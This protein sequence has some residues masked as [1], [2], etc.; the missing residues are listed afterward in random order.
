MKS[1]SVDLKEFGILILALHP[2]WVKTRMGGKN[3]PIETEACVRTMIKTLEGLSEK[4]HGVF[5]S[6]DNTPIQ[7]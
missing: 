1:L 5:L 3:A 4:D 7:W 6:Y 2:G